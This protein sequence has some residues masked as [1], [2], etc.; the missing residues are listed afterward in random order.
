METLM[1]LDFIHTFMELI[2]QIFKKGGGVDLKFIACAV[3][4]LLGMALIAMC[5]NLMQVTF[6]FIVPLKTWYLVFSSTT[7]LLSFHWPSKVHL[8]FTFN[9]N[10]ALQI[11]SCI[12]HTDQDVSYLFVVKLC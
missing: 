4:L 6:F 1:M 11:K 7:M 2:F 3:Y 12:P 10:F 9:D 5:F 8:E